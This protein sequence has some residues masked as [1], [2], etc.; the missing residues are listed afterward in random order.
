MQRDINDAYLRTVRPPETGR[1]EIWD[2]RT[3]GLVIRITP[4]GA[5][6]WSVRARTADGKKTRPALGTWPALGVAAARKAATA[7]LAAIQ[8]GKDLVAEKA[9]CQD[10]Q[11][12]SR[13]SPDRRRQAGTMAG[14]QERGMVA[15]GTAVTLQS[16][17]L[18][19]SRQP[20]P[21][22]L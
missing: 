9:G 13:C 5:M 10:G 12:G 3:N 11:D 2:T 7:A 19:R 16:L 17:L 4:T 22:S 20:W 1:L 21:R 8:G 15:T 14:S 18:P 6:T